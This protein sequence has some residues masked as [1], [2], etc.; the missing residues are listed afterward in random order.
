MQLPEHVVDIIKEF[1]LLPKEVFKIKRDFYNQ[2][3]LIN[4]IWVLTNMMDDLGRVR[5][6]YE[7]RQDRLNSAMNV[8]KRKNIPKIRVFRSLIFN[9]C[10]Y[11]ISMYFQLGAYF[12]NC[13]PNNMFNWTAKFRIGD[14]VKV[15][16][17]VGTSDNHYMPTLLKKCIVLNVHT[18]S[19]TVGLYDYFIEEG[20]TFLPV[21]QYLDT[22]SEYRK[23]HFEHQCILQQGDV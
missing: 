20:D 8:V 5:D 18:S 15:V 13:I 12:K 7:T 17:D 9:E 11:N 1:L 16:D 22:I 2:L 4:N 19:I 21:V 23:I 10:G 6:P 3:Q 14:I